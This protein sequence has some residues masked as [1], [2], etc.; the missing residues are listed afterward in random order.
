MAE[1]G[2]Y[3]ALG[4]SFAAGPG[5]RPR[6][7]GSPLLAGR[8][9]INYAHLTAS[10]LRMPLID[11]TYSGATTEDLLR[12]HRRGIPAQLD[13]VTPETRL[14][15][16]TAGGNDIGYLGA[17]TSAS[18]PRPLRSGRSIRSQLPDALPPDVVDRRFGALAQR[19]LEVITVIQAVAPGA[20]VIIVDYLTVLPPSGTPSPG[21][22]SHADIEWARSVAARLTRT[23]ETVAA[24]SDATLVR[25]ADASAGH[26]AWSAEPWTNRFKIRFGGRRRVP[27]HGRR[28]AGRVGTGPP[29]P[30]TDR[31]AR[32]GLTATPRGRDA[33]FTSR[34]AAWSAARRGPS[35]ARPG[36]VLAPRTWTGRP[37]RR[38]RRDPR[39]APAS[40]LR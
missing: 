11:V 5:L 2:N 36:T 30:R 4:S 25:V 40:P 37:R 38:R 16:I 21:R 39:P 3:V 10:A 15:T 29:A 35:A 32:R 13:A 22:L 17:L 34:D 28:H 8:S 7:Q 14:V 27:P 23:Y 6:A 26:H 20:A 31:R 18:L 33:R 9:A 19:L 24:E 1:S 12:P